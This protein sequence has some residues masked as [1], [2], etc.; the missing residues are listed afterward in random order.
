MESKAIRLCGLLLNAS[1]S[2][3]I[4][5]QN[6]IVFLPVSTRLFHCNRTVF[7]EQCSF[8]SQFETCLKYRP[9]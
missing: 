4:Q 1:F 6:D 5:T 3:Q 2:N 8:E 9:P 7:Y